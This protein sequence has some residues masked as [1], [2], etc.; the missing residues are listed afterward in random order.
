[1]LC[2]NKQQAI[3]IIA[4]VGFF[5][6]TAAVATVPSHIFLTILIFFVTL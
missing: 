1:V 5:V 6:S 2:Y 4:S 3:I